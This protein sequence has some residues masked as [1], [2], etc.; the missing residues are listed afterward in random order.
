MCHCSC[1]PEFL[2]LLP[3]VIAFTSKRRPRLQCDGTDAHATSEVAKNILTMA[4]LT[5]YVTWNIVSR[6]CTFWISEYRSNPSTARNV[7]RETLA[8][9]WRQKVCMKVLQSSRALCLAHAVWQDGLCLRHG[10]DGTR[11]SR[12]E[13]SALRLM[14]LLDV[15]DCT[16]VLYTLSRPGAIENICH[17]NETITYTAKT[18]PSRMMHGS[19]ESSVQS[20]RALCLA[21]VVLCHIYASGKTVYLRIC[22]LE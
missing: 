2:L 9:E 12:Q 1:A 4:S 5:H 8:N 20:S 6:D 18:V 16:V 19:G 17:K 3:C 7:R 10:I 15:C 21:T 11:Q 13:L 14:L 22:L